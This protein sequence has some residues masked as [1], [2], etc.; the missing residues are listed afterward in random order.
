MFAQI[1][2][3]YL[4]KIKFRIHHTQYEQSRDCSFIDFIRAINKLSQNI[5][6]RQNLEYIYINLNAKIG[7]YYF[8]ELFKCKYLGFKKCSIIF[9][10]ESFSLQPLNLELDEYESLVYSMINNYSEN[11]DF[12][13]NY[14]KLYDHAQRSDVNDGIKNNILKFLNNFENMNKLISGSK[15][16]SLTRSH[17]K[18]YFKERKI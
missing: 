11:K 3:K 4:K 2:Y 16:G 10:D 8:T 14:A 13:L 5:S 7:N 6:I 17:L 1:D 9:E 18:Y 15:L 12:C